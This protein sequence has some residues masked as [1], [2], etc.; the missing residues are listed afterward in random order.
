MLTER[1]RV[2][3][4]IAKYLE[5][6]SLEP[7]EYYDIEGTLVKTVI[8]PDYFTDEAANARL[9][10]HAKISIEWADGHTT[11][12]A[13]FSHPV[14]VKLGMFRHEDRKTAV[15]LAFLKFAGIEVAHEAS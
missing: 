1:Q 3:E 15:V 4:A 12:G 2:N 9:V 6:K 7:F 13:Y 5:P 14:H 8:C 11:W 10:D